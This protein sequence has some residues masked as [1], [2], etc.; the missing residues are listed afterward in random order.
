M[1]IIDR[2]TH[3]T[4]AVPTATDMVKRECPSS[5]PPSAAPLAK[6]PRQSKHLAA[7]PR[8]FGGR[9]D[10]LTL[11][12]TN[13]LFPTVGGATKFF[14]DY[15]LVSD[16]QVGG[17]IGRRR[18]YEDSRFLVK[19]MNVNE[20][21]TVGRH[22]HPSPCSSID[23]ML[24]T[25]FSDDL[26]IFI[27]SLFGAG[28]VRGQMAVLRVDKEGNHDNPQQVFWRLTNVKFTSVKHFV[29]FQ[30]RFKLERSPDEDDAWYNL[31]YRGEH[32]SDVQLSRDL[33]TNERYGDDMD[34]V[35]RHVNEVV[36]SCSLNDCMEIFC[37][38]S[39]AVESMEVEAEG[40]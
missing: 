40:C 36:I 15:F 13:V 1:T 25:G 32:C 20:T 6:R 16:E 2:T 33:Y 24:V 8:T 4:R 23:S 37:G 28:Q 7:V 27:E 17:L 10:L 30:Q 19:C 29:E 11:R 3:R 18:M 14:H 39:N 35:D 26:P 12:L 9:Y 38:L 31:A 34:T 22:N 21:D 5:P